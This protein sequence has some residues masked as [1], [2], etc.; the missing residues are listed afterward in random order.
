VVKLEAAG[1]YAFAQDVIIDK[2]EE[3]IGIYGVRNNSN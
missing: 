3:L 2:D 1:R